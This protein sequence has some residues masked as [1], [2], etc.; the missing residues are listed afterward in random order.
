MLYLYFLNLIQNKTS[1][2]VLPY[3]KECGSNLKISSPNCVE[4]PVGRYHIYPHQSLLSFISTIKILE[5][6]SL[7]DYDKITYLLSQFDIIYH[8][9]KIF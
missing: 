2:N 1:R 8:H 7:I 4:I 6:Y 5:V 3:F 9:L